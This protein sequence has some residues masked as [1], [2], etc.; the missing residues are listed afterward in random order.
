M[1][2]QVPA[3]GQPFAVAASLLNA[4]VLV[5]LHCSGHCW[6]D[7]LLVVACAKA[8]ASAGA[9]LTAASQQIGVEGCH[10][11]PENNKATL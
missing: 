5:S 9:D 3:V 7:W 4:A 10:P 2:H 11:Q 8:A 6:K 1:H